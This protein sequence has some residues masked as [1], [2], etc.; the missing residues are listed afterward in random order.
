MDA[1]AVTETNAEVI[2]RIARTVPLNRPLE[3]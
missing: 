3:W 2:A 1:D